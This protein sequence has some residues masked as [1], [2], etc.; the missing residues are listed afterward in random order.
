MSKVTSCK[1]LLTEASFVS[2]LQITTMANAN[3]ELGTIQNKES[4][5]GSKPFST[6]IND[7][8]F[9]QTRRSTTEVRI[10]A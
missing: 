8:K 3:M 4:L 10:V 6:N 5:N 2:W 7:M 9:A 1:N